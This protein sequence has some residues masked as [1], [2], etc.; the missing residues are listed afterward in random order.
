MQN[1][2]NIVKHQTSGTMET[3]IEI[4]LLTDHRNTIIQMEGGKTPCAA[5]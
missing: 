4:L 2:N 5:V 1:V 3:V